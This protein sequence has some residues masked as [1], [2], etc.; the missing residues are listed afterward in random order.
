[1]D[2]GDTHCSSSLEHTFWLVKSGLAA[3]RLAILQS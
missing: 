1:V 3:R 2:A